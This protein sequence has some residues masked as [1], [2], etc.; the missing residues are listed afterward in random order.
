MVSFWV[1]ALFHLA[2]VASNSSTSTGSVLSSCLNFGLAVMTGPGWLVVFFE[3]F[4]WIKLYLIPIFV[5]S[6]CNLL[7]V[8]WVGV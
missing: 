4:S 7:Q 3:R 8:Q 6:F 1:V 5:M 2:I